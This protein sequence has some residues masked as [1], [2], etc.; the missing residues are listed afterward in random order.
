VL[1]LHIGESGTSLFVWALVGVCIEPVCPISCLCLENYSCIHNN[2]NNNN[3]N[4]NKNNYTN[5]INIFGRVT[6][7]DTVNNRRASLKINVR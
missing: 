4:N 1:T 6:D 5:N 3:S 7:A 2:N